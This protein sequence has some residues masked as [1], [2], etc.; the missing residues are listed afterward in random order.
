MSVADTSIYWDGNNLLSRNAMWN[1]AVGGRGLG[2]TFFAKKTN[3]KRGTKVYRPFIYM[4]R[5]KPE[6]QDKDRFLNDVLKYFPDCEFKVD[7]M[8]ISAKRVDSDK[9]F[10][11][12]YLITLA[13]AL[14]KKSIPYNDVDWIVFDEFIIPRKG[15]TRYLP[16]E[17]EAFQDFYN[18]VDRFEDRVKVLFLANSVSIVNPYFVY[19]GLKPRKGQKFFATRDNYHCVEYIDSTKYQ[20]HVDSTRFGQ[21]I[22]GT[23]YYDYAV[24]NVFRDDHDTF[25]KKKTPEA[26][27]YF[28]IIFDGRTIG[29][30]VDYTNGEYFITNTAPSDIRITYALTKHDMAPNLLMLERSSVVLKSVKMLY[31]QGSVFFNSV[32]TREFFNDIMD[33]VGLR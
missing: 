29:V 20:Q 19:Y 6:F 23:G 18:T 11:I 27:P 25:I 12:C 21:M 9:W 13:S 22:K 31:M 24:G 1:Y 28:K 14:S 10:P 30:W 15:M 3:I 33:Y 5:Y 26:K 17:V 8:V 2:K 4:R 32:Q 16:N 7:G